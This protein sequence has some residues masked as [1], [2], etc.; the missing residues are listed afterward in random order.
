MT[1]LALKTI[2]MGRFALRWRFTDPRYRVLPSTH[3]VQIKPIKAHAAGQLVDLISDWDPLPPQ[4]QAGFAHVA[5]T[6]IDAYEV[7]EVRRVR[8]WLF[9]RPL[10]FKQEVFV[11]WDRHTA[12]ITTWKMIVRYWDVFWYPSSDDVCVFD[13]SLAWLLFLWHEEE[14]FFA[15]HRRAPQ[16]RSP[17][18]W[19]AL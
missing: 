11:C 18:P 14:A 2:P 15:S 10:P 16:T 3:L 13:T 1:T 8:K 12:A 9:Q 17:A 5:R 4:G 6:R 19:P 7:D